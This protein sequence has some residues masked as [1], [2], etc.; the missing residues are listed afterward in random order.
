MQ[1]F[2][3][4][5]ALTSDIESLPPA[6][7]ETLVEEFKALPASNGDPAAIN[8]SFAKENADKSLG[9]VVAAVAVKQSFNKEGSEQES[10]KTLKERVSRPEVGIEEAL[11]GLKL[12]DDFGVKGE[13]RKEYVAGAKERWTEATVFQ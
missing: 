7:K 13:V 4:R 3:F 9:H 10:A 2:R 11:A 12:I 8:E 1:T 6:I 5:S